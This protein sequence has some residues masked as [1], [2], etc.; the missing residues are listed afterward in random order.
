M[1]ASALIF[2]SPS[3]T[4]LR[5]SLQKEAS[6]L[7]SFLHNYL[8][9]LSSVTKPPRSFLLLFEAYLIIITSPQRS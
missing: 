3:E 8:K 2:S 6:A 7:I 5:S 4:I 9:T 1:I